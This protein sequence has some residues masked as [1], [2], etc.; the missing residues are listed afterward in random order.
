MRGEASGKRLQERRSRRSDTGSLIYREN[1]GE[2]TAALR[3][4]ETSSSNHPIKGLSA[5]F[6]WRIFFALFRFP[7]QAP[8]AGTIDDAKLF[9]NM[10]RMPCLAK[11]SL[12]NHSSSSTPFPIPDLSFRSTMPVCWGAH[13]PGTV[14]TAESNRSH[15]CCQGDKTTRLRQTGATRAAQVSTHQFWSPPGYKAAPQQ[16]VVVTI[17]CTAGKG[18]E[19]LSHLCVGC[20]NITPDGAGG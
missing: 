4:K 11:R 20:L 7:Q 15:S 13:C 8:A 9:W 18:W 5:F 17:P 14:G 10:L 1:W 12:I 19:Q 2:E 16:P 3:K 6:M